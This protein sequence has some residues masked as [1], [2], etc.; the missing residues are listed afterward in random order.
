MKKQHTN[1]SFVF[2]IVMLLNFTTNLAYS[3]GVTEEEIND[4]FD[5]AVTLFDS[6]KYDEALAVF[7]KIIIDYK[8]NSKTTASEFFKAKT[9]LEVEAV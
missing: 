9:H 2:F 4:Q 3:Q 7:N 5:D 1:I 6:G 8:Y